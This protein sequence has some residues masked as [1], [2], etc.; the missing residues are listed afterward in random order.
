MTCQRAR[1]KNN[2]I[3]KERSAG[4]RTEREIEREMEGKMER[5]T[6]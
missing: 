5:A 4:D 1:G 6:A 3:T 2:G